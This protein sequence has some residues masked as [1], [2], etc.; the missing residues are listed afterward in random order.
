M[1]KYKMTI[2]YDGTDYSGWQAQ[3]N[4]LS[5]QFLIEQAL[6]T[7]LSKDI[8]ITGSG[9]T[10]SGVHALGQVA[11]FEVE[12]S[13]NLYKLNHSLNSLLPKAIRILSMEETDPSFHARYDATGKIYHYHLRLDK[14]LSPFN[15]LYSWHVPHKVDLTLLQKAAPLF[16]GTHDFT[17]FANDAD[18]GSAATDAVRTIKRLDVVEE[19]GGVRLE[20][21]GD[22]FLYKMVRNITGT[23]MDA[24]SGRLPLEKIPKILLAKDRQQAGSTAP[25]HGLFLIKVH[26]PLSRSK[27]EEN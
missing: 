3:K 17:S 20:F 13:L 24:S 11:H 6:A 22:G 12:E 16:I 10:D 26:Y 25:P 4:A 15:R 23:L 27:N 14:L 5:I 19:E 9:R 8:L 21:E 18:K 7:V 2:A 1:K